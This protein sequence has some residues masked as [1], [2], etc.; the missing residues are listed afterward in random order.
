MGAGP[1]PA[2]TESEGIVFLSPNAGAGT[3][4]ADLTLPFAPPSFADIGGDPGPLIAGER[5]STAPIGKSIAPPI[6]PPLS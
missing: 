2:D 5:N 4:A 1:F 6:R 3:G